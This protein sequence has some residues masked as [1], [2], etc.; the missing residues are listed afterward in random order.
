MQ[1]ATAARSLM[2]L[3]EVLAATGFFPPPVD[4]KYLLEPDFYGMLVGAI[5][6]NSIC[7]ELPSP[8]RQ[9]VIETKPAV[10]GADLRTRISQP[11]QITS[12]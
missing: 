8:A 10:P 6:Q 1:Q 11:G 7:I 2:L 9:Y 3:K 12:I 4:A 5:L